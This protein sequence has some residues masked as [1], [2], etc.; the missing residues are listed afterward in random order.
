MLRTWISVAVVGLVGL[1]PALVAANSAETLPKG[2]FVLGLKYGYKWADKRFDKEFGPG[3]VPITRDY[4]ITIY[5]RDLGAA[6]LYEPDDIIGKTDVT[7]DNFGMEFTFTTAYGLTDNL[8]IMMILPIQYVNSKYDADV[9]DSTLYLVRDGQGQP[10]AMTNKK[11]RA[12]MEAMGFSV[13][14]DTLTGDQ[15]KEALSCQADTPLCQF[16]YRPIRHYKRWGVGDIIL[17]LRYKFMETPMWRQGITLFSKVGTGRHD[18]PDDLFDTNFGDQNLDLGFWYGIDFIPLRTDKVD[19]TLNI[20]AG[21]TDQLPDT[22]ERRIASRTYDEKG[23]EMG[24]I[25]ITQYWQKMLVH[26]DIGGNFDVYGSWTVGLFKFLSIG[27]DYYYFWKYEDNF[28]AA[29]PPPRAPD[30]SKWEPD[31]RAMEYGTN[32][33]GLEMTSMISISTVDWM[34]RGK[35]PIPLFFSVGYTY[36]IAGK[37]FE[38]N[39]SIFVSLDLVGSIFMFESEETAKPENE[40]KVDEFRLPGRSGLDE[41]NRPARA[42]VPAQAIFGNSPKLGW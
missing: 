40:E 36:G 27:Q 34:Q 19:L 1:W 17:G 35:F 32:Q 24:T 22:K 37:N 38:Q 39:Q 20:T 11:H 2:V 29:E 41:P 33:V 18:H 26:R 7:Y 5:G 31:F 30:G 42:S 23:R 28:A 4:N 15:F 9:Y 10:Y 6:P 12:E 25:P 13:E 21:Y 16:R 8:A 14:K 3:T